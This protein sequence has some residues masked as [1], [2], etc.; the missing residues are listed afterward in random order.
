MT[1]PIAVRLKTGYPQFQSKQDIAIIFNNF[2][3]SN[4]IWE[5][6]LQIC[7]WNLQEEAAREVTNGDREEDPRDTG[8]VMVPSLVALWK[9]G[10]WGLNLCH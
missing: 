6:V 7:C 4:A 3:F 1:I 10:R 5:A 8:G 2:P 9:M